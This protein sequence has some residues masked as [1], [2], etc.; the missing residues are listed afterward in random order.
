MRLLVTENYEA[1]SRLAADL[2]AGFVEAQPRGT[3]VLATG[4][5]PMGA[6]AELAKRRQEQ[7]F[8]AT[9]L[10]V[11]QLDEY[12]GLE[13][14]DE[15]SLYGWMDRSFLQPQS[16]P[17]ENVLRLNGNSAD[18]DGDCRKYDQTL[19]STGGYDLSVLGLGPNGHLA[20]NEPPAGSDSASRVITLSQESLASNAAYWGGQDKVPLRAVTA[21]LKHLLAARQTILLVSGAHKRDILQKVL[22]GP[23]TPSVP[24][25]YLQL[26]QNVTIIADKEAAGETRYVLGV[27][28]GNTKTLAVI[29][30]LNGDVVGSGRAGCG[31]IYANASPEVGL[32]SIY[33]AVDAALACAGLSAD[34]L[35]AACFSLAGAD[36]PEDFELLHEAIRSRGYGRQIKVVNDAV[37]GLR[38]GSS[39]ATG[40]AIACGTGCATS[41]AGK[42][43]KVW[44]SSFWQNQGG[45]WGL[46]YAALRAVYDAELGIIPPTA[47]TAAVL[48]FCGQ[49]DVEHVLHQ[50]T[51]R[52]HKASVRVDLLAKTVLDL[53]HAGDEAA[54]SVVKQQAL[55]MADGALAAAR[56]VGIMQEHYELV[57]TGSVFRHESSLLVQEIVERVK[58][59]SP[60]VMPIKSTNEPVYGAVLMA[61][62]SAGISLN[63][64]VRNNLRATMPGAEFYGADKGS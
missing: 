58:S 9:G 33:Q 41:A 44:H 64:S 2:I 28:G 40:V 32:G 27:D 10:R 52:G 49:P 45:A 8:D 46:G 50:F 22:Y 23:V 26:A 37:G 38:S 63:D 55:L 47:L 6:Y 18:P 13:D 39:G 53:A 62:E 16:V 54:L 30:T 15:R 5:T 60:H 3:V 14:G 48:S 61:L 31:D 4:N 42:D 57:L 11:C 1:L 7:V 20:F 43:G 56:K 25:S 21:G 34:K 51:R 17:P 19:D 36:W 12:L 59:Q 29:A 35:D 24:A